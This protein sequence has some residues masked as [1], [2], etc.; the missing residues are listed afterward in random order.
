MQ[1]HVIWHMRI[2]CKRIVSESL[3]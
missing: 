3:W 1:G 2:G